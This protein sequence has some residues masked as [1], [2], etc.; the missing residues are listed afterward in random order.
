[1]IKKKSKNDI[2]TRIENLKRQIEKAAEEGIVSFGEGNCPPEIKEKFLEYVLA[3]E[4]GA[5]LCIFD[6]LI[7]NG[8]SLP[9]PD[10]LDDN[11]LTKKLWETIQLLSLL[12]AYLYNT[13]HL[14]DRE[15][16]EHLWH[17]SLREQV[18]L[19]PGNSDYAYCID[20]IGSGSDEDIFI[21]LK[22]YSDEKHRR[23]WADEFPQ[24]V[25]PAREE[26]PYDRDRHLP[27]KD[28]WSKG[29]VCN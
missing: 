25:I 12:G 4:T 16:Y 9:E 21:D 20:M 14:S 5:H 1:M 29:K 8:I 24:D 10:D 27:Q 2:E 7:K 17:E 11:Q 28:M 22:Y 18:F 23:W 15:L 6:V 13:D 26:K 19:H 3:F